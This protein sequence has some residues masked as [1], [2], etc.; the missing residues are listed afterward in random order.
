MKSIPRLLLCAALAATLSSC[1]ANLVRIKQY[2]RGI[3]AKNVMADAPDPLLVSMTDHAY[4][5]REG[6]F[7]GGGVGGGG[8]GCN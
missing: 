2:E 4:F 6:S 5:S 1:S 7:G 3:L 8:C